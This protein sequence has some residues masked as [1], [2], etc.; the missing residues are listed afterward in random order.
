MSWNDP[1][2]YRKTA[3]KY[4][5]DLASIGDQICVADF[6]HS[7]CSSRLL[8]QLLEI[9]DESSRNIVKTAIDQVVSSGATP[10][11]GGL[12]KGY[13]ELSSPRAVAGHS[14]AGI[15]LTDGDDTCG[16]EGA[17][18]TYAQNFG[19]NG[20][21]LDTIG[22]TGYAD[23][24]LLRELA[25]LGNGEYYKA[26]TNVQLME[27][28]NA[29]SGR[30]AGE[31]TL[32]AARGTVQ[33][34]STSVE[35]ALIDSSV[36]KARFTISWAGSDL[37]LTLKQPDGSIIDPDVAKID[38]NINY[39][40]ASSYEFYTVKYPMPG[41]W[42][43]RIFGA[44]VPAG[45]EDYT[46][47]VMGTTN[48]TMNM[49]FDRDQYSVGEPIKVSVSLTDA[50]QPI[51]EA[52]VIADIELSPTASASLKN[53]AGKDNLTEEEKSELANL[54]SISLQTRLA[55]AP[56]QITL[57]DDGM[58]GDGM[59]NDGVYANF[60]TNT[61][62][63][64]TYKF[65]AKATGTRSPE[66]F[67]R[68]IEQ[69]TYVSGAPTPDLSVTP[70]SWDITSPQDTSV[71]E[72]FTVESSA[73]T[74]ASIA[75]TDLTDGFGNVIQSSNFIFNT[76]ILALP[77]NEP[78]DFTANLS[79]P[80]NSPVGDYT[81]SIIITAPEGTLNIELKVTISNPPIADANGPYRGVIRYIAVPITFDGTGSYDPDGT[82]VK[83]EWD[84]D[85]DGDYD[86]TFG[87]TPTVSFTAPG[88]GNIHL[89]V[90][91]NNGAT[92]TDSTTLTI[93]K[94]SPPPNGIHGGLLTP[95]EQPQCYSGTSTIQGS[96]YFTIDERIQDWAT[97]IDTTEHM[98][99][100]GEFE[101]DSKTVLDQ[102]AN[103]LDFYD[104]NFYHKKTMQ[105]QGNATNR[106]INQE[107]FESSGIFGGTGTR[108]SEY[109]DVSMIQKD[110][111]SSIKT[112]SAPGSGQSHKFATMDDFSGI[113]GIHSDWQKICQK[114]IAHHQLFKGNFSVQK[115]LTFEREVVMP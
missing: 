98:E 20:W 52:S 110:E 72:S 17:A 13:D 44:D 7:S 34:G 21:V 74:I 28:Y 49:Y 108:V 31:Q 41:E 54:R 51:T 94:H 113:W 106:L 8:L 36:T 96:G 105:F 82:I 5:V 50:I 2:G 56:D 3:A 4:F 37:N 61:D 69:S 103:P 66:E 67:E 16:T 80:L 24:D 40:S 33:Q 90:T 23:E 88:S 97:A 32:G 29:I 102:A 79:I 115:D 64:G 55:I 10:I 101:M 111:S 46:A 109:F 107:K 14:K 104:P 47:S 89:K 12:E 35:N 99:G 84:L 30:V 81:G 73:N 68:V 71:E 95:P 75:A 83:Y 58:H 43:L 57:F 78:Q 11:G 112:I 92:D 42:E 76:S 77:A 85:D 93:T 60:Y 114:E 63:E 86:D 1:Q 26:P 25:A 62:I 18:R 27:I 22:L 70:T 48:L 38:P 87:A 19:D 53:L 45:G 39:T 65:T 100:T 91:D 9:T 15:L 6:G 59:A